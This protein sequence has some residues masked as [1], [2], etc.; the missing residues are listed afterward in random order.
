MKKFYDMQA[1]E[2]S[3]GNIT[4]KLQTVY[5]P[6]ND[7]YT[8][9]Y[10]DQILYDNQGGYLQNLD[11]KSGYFF[12]EEQLKQLLSDAFDKGRD[13]QT[14]FGVINSKQTFIENFLNKEL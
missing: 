8:E 3:Y 6:T 13:Y 5:I 11:E 9:E 7:E 4:S 10:T 2:G 12:T 14:D 1:T